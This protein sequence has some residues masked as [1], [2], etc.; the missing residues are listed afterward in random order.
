MSNLDKLSE[1]IRNLDSDSL[2]A[3]ALASVVGTEKSD[4][5]IP[6][7][8]A[9][10]QRM[11]DAFTQL[12]DGKSIDD[13]RDLLKSAAGLL[14]VSCGEHKADYRTMSKSEFEDF[15]A[16]EIAKA[17]ESGA[18][19][20]HL[21]SL[22]IA[23]DVAAVLFKGDNAD[24][25]FKIPLPVMAKS[26]TTE[27]APAAEGDEEA[28]AADDAPTGETEAAPA[29]G[30]EAP[31]AEAAPAAEEAAPAAEAAAEGDDEVAKTDDAEEGKPADEVVAKSADDFDNADE[32]TTW[33]LDMSVK[34]SDDPDWGYD[35]AAE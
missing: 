31:A 12:Q 9:A 28:P 21:S 13:V 18:A 15:A 6:L 19:G 17:A 16:G 35:T 3:A 11:W 34:K 27:E 14:L 24:R 10:G 7:V 25:K 1:V 33:P 30:E 5:A 23:I 8:D 26:D 4:S 32:V 29:E 20:E 2:V 22:A